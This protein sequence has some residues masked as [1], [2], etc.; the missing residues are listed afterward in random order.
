MYIHQSISTY[1]YHKK[2][3]I[4]KSAKMCKNLKCDKN[5]HKWIKIYFKYIS[6]PHRT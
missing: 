1:I 5:R 3:K 6:E 2:L 4:D